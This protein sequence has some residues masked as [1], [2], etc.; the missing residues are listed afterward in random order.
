[1]KTFMF[2]VTLRVEDH[3]K[4]REVRDY[5]FNAV[6]FAKLE[7]VRDWEVYGTSNP[8]SETKVVSVKNLER[9]NR[10]KKS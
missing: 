7:T 5:I 10:R 2:Q 3:I 6:D 1:M 9:I 4:E 8:M